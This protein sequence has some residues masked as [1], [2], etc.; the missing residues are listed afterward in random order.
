MRI[1]KDHAKLSEISR[2]FCLEALA[3]GP[4][5]EMVSEALAEAGQ[6]ESR[7]SPLQPRLVLWLVMGLA[8]WR[9]DSIPAVFGRLV[10]GLRDRFGRI[11]LKAVTQ[12][13]L[14]HARRRLGV[15]PLKRL[16]KKLSQRVEGQEAFHGLKCWILDGTKLTMQDTPANEKV[17]G[18]RTASRGRTAFCELGMVCLVEATRHLVRDAVFGMWKTHEKRAALRLIRHL[19]LGDLLILD[20]GFYGLELF[21]AILSRGIHFLCRAPS[22]PKLK[23]IRGTRRGHQYEAWMRTRIMVD[24]KAPFGK[25]TRILM[26]RVRVIDYRLKGYG[27]VRLV[28]SLMDAELYP[29]HELAVLYHTRWEAEIAFDEIKTHQNANAHGQ[30][31]TVFRSKTP[32]NVLQ[33]AYALL[34]VYNLVRQTMAR[35]A[36]QGG[37]D[38]LHLSFLDGLR[39]V[40]H[41]IPRMQSA[42]VERLPA[43]HR[44]LLADVAEAVIDRP[45]RGRAY[46]RVLRV[47]IGHFQLKRAHHRQIVRDFAE[48]VRRAAA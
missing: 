21:E 40:R 32:R 17:F 47:K 44:Q 9:D 38:P 18:R 7:Q 19:G 46:P 30:L 23:P 35:S 25:R 24:P 43:L 2:Q 42:S 14:S 26:R 48:M 27:R 13:A 20:R 29:A 6:L 28:T 10:S 3:D 11:S 1:G 22:I 5:P 45:R 36:Q 31:Q 41:M 8:L 33:E 12:G 39:A 4:I 37:L 16:F 34:A 15:R